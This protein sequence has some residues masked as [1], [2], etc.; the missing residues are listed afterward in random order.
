M[1]TLNT[2]AAEDM[3]RCIAHRAKSIAYT[4][5]SGW[6]KGLKAVWRPAV[7]MSATRG[8]KTRPLKRTEGTPSA[9]ERENRRNGEPGKGR[10]SE[11]KKIR[12]W[13]IQCFQCVF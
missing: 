3:L 8:M 7:G 12:S 6:G 4:L 5:R 11:V 2:P 10:I 1:C 13:E 9:G